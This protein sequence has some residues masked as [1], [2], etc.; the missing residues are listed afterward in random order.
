MI[1]ITQTR[2]AIVNVDMENN[3]G[4]IVIAPLDDKF[5]IRYFV[6]DTSNQYTVIGTYSSFAY[7]QVVLGNIFNS[8]TL[9]NY[10]YIMDEDRVVAR[11]DTE[12]VT[13]SANSDNTAEN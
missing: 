12:S 3:S 5:E 11:T 9:R 2:D 1:I 13:V 4:R 7:A 6:S 10:S 8:F